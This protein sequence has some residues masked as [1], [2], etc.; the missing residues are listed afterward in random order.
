MKRIKIIFLSCLFGFFLNAQD[1]VFTITE[2]APEFPGGITEMMKFIQTNISYPSVCR[3]G[4]IGGKV[5]LKFIVNEEG[6]VNNV[7]V[8]KSSGNGFLDGEAVRIVK[9]MPVWKPGMMTGKAV[10]C[11]FNLPLIFSM[12]D[13]FFIFNV[14]NKSDEYLKAIVHINNR[15]IDKAKELLNESDPDQL[16]LLAVIDYMKK[17]KKKACKKFTKYIE[18]TQDKSGQKA[19]VASTYLEKSC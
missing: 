12:T 2:V 8:L 18:I 16:Y 3:D 15:N 14:A 5:F 10:K 1:E 19:K 11:Y 9:A 7:E 17:D 6:F 4:N 13:P